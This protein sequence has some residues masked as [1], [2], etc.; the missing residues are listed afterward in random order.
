M[1]VS[2]C[3]TCGSVVRNGDTCPECGSH[4]PEKEAIRRLPHEVVHEV[5][6]HAEDF[7]TSGPLRQAALAFG[8]GSFLSLRLEP[9]PWSD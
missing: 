5:L 4:L 9:G 2:I 6:E 8:A 3:E 7:L 1:T